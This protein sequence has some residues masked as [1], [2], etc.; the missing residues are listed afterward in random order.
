MKRI[1]IILGM[2][3]L[4]L[5]GYALLRLDVWWAERQAADRLPSAEAGR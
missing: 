5:L 2:L 3:A 4:L 1:R